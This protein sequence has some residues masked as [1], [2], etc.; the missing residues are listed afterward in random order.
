ML[1][2]YR[3]TLLR[4]L[5]KL[6]LLRTSPL[7]SHQLCLDIQET[8]IRKITYLEKRIQVLKARIKE[9]KISLKTKRSVPL[10]KDEANIIKSRIEHSQYLI[11]EYQNL[12]YTF[13][14]I[15]DA[16]AFTYLDKWDIKP[17]TFKESTGN[18]LGKEGARLERGAFRKALQLGHIAILNDI[19]NCLRYGDITV[20]KEGYPLI[21]EMKSGKVRNDRTERQLNGI[22]K[23]VNYWNTDRA[24]GLYKDNFDMMRIDAHSTDTHHREKLNEIIRVALAKGKNWLEV[25]NGVYYYVAKDFDITD[26]DA[27]IS[28]CVGELFIFYVNEAKY[29]NTAYYPFSLSIED[30]DAFLEFYAGELSIFVLIDTAVIVS[31]LASKGL[32]VSFESDEPFAM[33][34]TFMGAE[35]EDKANFMKIS[36]HMFGRIAC[37]F[38]SLNWLLEEIISKAS[39]PYKLLESEIAA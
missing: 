24:E 36:R 16:L 18:L 17:L 37:E 34:L 4:L 31:K 19:T 3:Q 32:A 21:F 6:R 2:Y 22:E 28:K 38:M 11:D 7:E 26:V 9:Q 14:T 13:K 20:P 5:E 1:I 8:L 12:K 35:G 23:I 33:D 25:E 29:S 10:T 15:G 39:N 30:P 27:I